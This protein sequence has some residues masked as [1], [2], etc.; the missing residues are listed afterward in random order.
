MAGKTRR[1]QDL[2]AIITG[3]GAGIGR[4]T[5]EFFAEE[6]DIFFLVT[7]SWNSRYFSES[8]FSSSIL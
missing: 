7:L 6:G 1:V 4:A 2:V 5:A 3:S 8:L